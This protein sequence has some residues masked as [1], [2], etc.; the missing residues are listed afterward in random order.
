MQDNLNPFTGTI[1]IIQQ[2]GYVIF[3]ITMVLAKYFPFE[4]QE[5]LV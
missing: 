5:S 2:F 4:V 3:T 1:Y